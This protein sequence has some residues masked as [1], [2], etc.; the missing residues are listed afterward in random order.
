[1][2]LVSFSCLDSRVALISRYS[3]D[4]HKGT[5]QKGVQTPAEATG[6][7]A[8]QG[9]NEVLTDGPYLDTTVRPV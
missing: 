5:S 1:M 2:A 6:G 4:L 7:A 9:F 8:Q 3:M